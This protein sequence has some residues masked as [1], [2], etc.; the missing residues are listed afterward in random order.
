VRVNLELE[1]NCNSYDTL[2]LNYTMFQILLIHLGL[3]ASIICIFLL[4]KLLFGNSIYKK[5]LNEAKP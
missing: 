2:R 1:P 3:P 5:A 4:C